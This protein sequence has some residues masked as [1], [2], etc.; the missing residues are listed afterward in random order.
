MRTSDLA[1][2]DLNL[3]VVLHTLLETRSVTRTAERLGSSQPAISRSLAKLRRLFDDR[4]MVKGA[5]GMMPTLRAETMIEPLASLLGNVESFLLKPKFDPFTT[6][7]V[8]RI[9]TTDYGALAILPNVA[10]R[11]AREAPN[12]AIEIVG[13]SREVFRTLAE[14]QL[15]L[16]LYSDNPVPGSLRTRELFRE[17]FVTLVRS[18]HP[19]LKQM[20]GAKDLLPLKLFTAWPHILVSVFG[21]QGGPI[22]TALAEQG[23]TRHIALRVPYFATAA[24]IT[25]ASDFLV[26]MPSRAAYQLAPRLGLVILKTPVSVKPYGYRLLWHERSHG[27]AGAVWLRRLV[28]EGVRLARAPGGASSEDR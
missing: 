3:L 1:G 22:D 7:R 9:A 19:L 27:D 24:V 5:S 26:T 28:I 11:F 14:G 4:L 17:S 18:G 6:D 2:I 20:R 12:A 10:A 13:F 15:D 16:V 23:K 25:A 8:F 21:G